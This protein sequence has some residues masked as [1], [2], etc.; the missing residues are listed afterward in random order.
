[1]PRW[2][3]LLWNVFG[4]MANV[5]SFNFL[6]LAMYYQVLKFDH[7]FLQSRF[8]TWSIDGPMGI[9]K[10]TSRTDVNKC[11]HC[12]IIQ[13]LVPYINFIIS[14]FRF[15][16]G[17]SCRNREIQRWCRKSSV[18]AKDIVLLAIYSRNFDYKTLIDLFANEAVNL[19]EN[20]IGTKTFQ[21]LQF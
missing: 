11:R 21:R 19:N 18:D 8:G 17:C 9:P 14:V 16:S 12:V 10:T 7:L 15:S 2:P 5:D 13:A 20:K 3:C 4:I 1:M 6:Y